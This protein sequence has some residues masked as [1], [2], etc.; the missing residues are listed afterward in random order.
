[1]S[2]MSAENNACPNTGNASMKFTYSP[3][4][5]LANHADKPSIQE[6]LYNRLAH[7]EAVLSA[8]DGEGTA[9]DSSCSQDGA[10]N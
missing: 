3:V 9:R 6:H 4:Y 10:T 1:M 2:D 7:L 8:I 5:T